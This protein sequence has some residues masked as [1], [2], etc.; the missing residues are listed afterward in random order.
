MKSKNRLVVVAILAVAL[1]SLF[2]VS[3]AVCAEWTVMGPIPTTETLNDV[4]GASS[5]AVFA[6][7]DRETILFF[8]GSSWVEQNYLVDGTILRDVWGNSD[9]NVYAVGDSGKILHYDG[10]WAEVTDISTTANLNGVW[11]SPNGEVFIV[12]A[13]PP[14]A[15]NSIILHY[16][17]SMWE[18]QDSGTGNT[19]NAVWGTSENEVF[20]V[21]ANGTILKYDGNNWVSMD[22][23]TITA[24]LTCIWGSSGSDVFSGGGTNIYYYDG[25]Q[26]GT[27][28][29]SVGVIE[30]PDDLWGAAS[31]DVYAVG[32][33]DYFKIEHFDGNSWGVQYNPGYHPNG[34]WGSSASNIFVVGNQGMILRYG[35]QHR[36]NKPT[37]VAPSN[38]AVFPEL[39]DITF[40]SSAFDDPDGV[41]THQSSSWKITRDDNGYVVVDIPDSDALTE[42]TMS[43]Y[44]SPGLKYVWQVMHKDN[45]GLESGWSDEFAFKVGTL[46]PDTLPTVEAGKSLGDFGM[47]SIVHWPDN[48]DPQAVF[49]I[50]YDP[51]KYRIGTWDPEQDKYIEFG[52]GLTMEPGR[53]YWILTRD[54]LV[55]NFNGVQVSMIEDMEVCLHSHPSTGVGWNMIAPPN[56]ANYL[57]NEVLVGRWVEDDP[58]LTVNPVPVTSPVAST[59]INHRIYEWKNGGYVDHKL[60]ENFVLAYYKGYWVKAIVDGAYLVFP[61]YA[62]ASGLSTP[63]NTLLAW[64][65]KAVR[66][67]KSL[68]P[69]PREAIADNDLPPMPMES[70]DGGANPMFEGCFVQTSLK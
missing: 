45:T 53:A 51:Q 39:S 62:R 27:W 30:Y 5:N 58:E 52:Q 44:L 59:L 11:V 9:S 19:L 49:N 20:A 36:P 37:R 65:G 57:W 29:E 15:N 55:V 3:G 7:G 31:N 32:G 40:K 60:D 24:W 64:K 13:V 22:T 38:E 1:C 12:G 42:Y 17:G 63:R 33:S 70:F 46:E 16:T 26:D 4:W 68:V 28:T 34:V 10:N 2:I 35:E 43:D 48:P 23:D 18:V 41:D 14:V 50:T 67:L 54:P 69:A 61:E 56:K 21:G 6:V 8:D 47:I 25:N 66:W